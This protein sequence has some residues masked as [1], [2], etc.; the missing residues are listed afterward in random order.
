MT[1]FGFTYT[2]TNKTTNNITNK[3][4]ICECNSCEDAL[5]ML[6]GEYQKFKRDYIIGD[7]IMR[8]C[9]KAY[10]EDGVPVKVPE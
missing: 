10:N 6:A 3:E 7:I 5:K 2:I 8:Y 4:F 1:E 9:K